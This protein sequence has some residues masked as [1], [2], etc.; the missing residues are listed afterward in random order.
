MTT[1]NIDVLYDET[2]N[3]WW[4]GDVVSRDVEDITVAR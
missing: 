1:D 3:D 4:Q 2:A